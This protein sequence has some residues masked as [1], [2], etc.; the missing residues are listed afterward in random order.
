MADTHETTHAS[1]ANITLRGKTVSFRPLTLTHVGMAHDD[2]C[3]I[4]DCTDV[5]AQDVFPHFLRVLAVSIKDQ[6]PDVPLPALMDDLA[7][8]LSPVDLL[9]IAPMVFDPANFTPYLQK[10]PAHG[11]H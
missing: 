3:V 9:V 5:L 4:R 10:E 1:P 7:D 2:L 8:T 11:I 6:F